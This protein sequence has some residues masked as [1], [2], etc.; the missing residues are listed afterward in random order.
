[1]RAG[2][3]IPMVRRKSGLTNRSSASVRLSA[4]KGR[5]QDALKVSDAALKALAQNRQILLLRAV[6]RSW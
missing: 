2:N 6:F 5:T 3:G 4:H 1:M